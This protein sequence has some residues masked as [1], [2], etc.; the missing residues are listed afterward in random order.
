MPGVIDVTIKTLD[1]NS[2]KLENVSDQLTV[3]DFKGK[4]A[5]RVSLPASKQKLLHAGKAL[6]D[7]SPLSEY[8]LDGQTIHLVERPAAA[9]NRPAPQPRPTQPGP[10][11][12]HQRWTRT[13]TGRSMS[14]PPGDADPMS[15]YDFLQSRQ[16]RLSL[17]E[18][19]GLINDG[20][21]AFCRAVTLPELFH[22][23][24]GLPRPLA[25][26]RSFLAQHI[27]ENMLLGEPYTDDL[28][29]ARISVL[30]EENRPHFRQ[31]FGVVSYRDNIDGTLTAL[32]FLKHHG[33]ILV[34][35]IVRPDLSDADFADQF[36]NAFR[37]FVHQFL[38]LFSNII[39]PPG[40]VTQHFESSAVFGD[41]EIDV[42]NGMAQL[43]SAITTP[44]SEVEHF[45]AYN[46][47]TE[48]CENRD[49]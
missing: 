38:R 7:R 39:A 1:E 30:S 9:T 6:N 4:I 25:R 27:R 49:S 22:L 26:T 15:L 23:M 34:T 41:A 31:Y 14:P 42:A 18:G 16:T 29:S 36:N 20:L 19:D 40:E 33:H 28:L 2:R 44:F 8:G 48:T 24:N 17:T 5:S 10:T 11:P 13:P 47:S 3:K 35:L 32:R 37:T 43:I 46:A 21:T 12:H 45:V